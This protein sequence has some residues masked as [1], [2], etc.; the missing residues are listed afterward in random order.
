MFNIKNYLYKIK[1]LSSQLV[2]VTFSHV[3]PNVQASSVHLNP[4]CI[5]SLYLCCVVCR[6]QVGEKK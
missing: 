6:S 5:G 3:A 4:K 1:V 2:L